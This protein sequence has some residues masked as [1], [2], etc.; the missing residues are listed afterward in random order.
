M[1][2]TL[3]ERR[4]R[5]VDAALQLAADQGIEHVNLRA[6]AHSAGI[7]WEAAQ[8]VF[9]DHTDLLQAMSTSVTTKNISPETL[10]LD[11]EGPVGE[12]LEAVALQVWAALSARRD[13]QLISYEIALIAL[14]R[15]VLRPL[16]TAQYDKARAFAL[17]ILIPFAE[18]QG[19]TWSRPIDEIARYTATF[20]DGVS[21]AWVVDRDDDAA[22]EQVRMMAQYLSSLVEES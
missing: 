8:E 21:M 19:I 6:A 5:L 18:H 4:D 15:T 17:S 14:R 20:L 1:G 10:K 3:E 7:A 12:V 22:A 9:D 13:Y 2:W 16:V 11:A